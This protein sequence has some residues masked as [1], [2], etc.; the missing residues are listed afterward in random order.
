MFLLNCFRKVF[1]LIIAEDVTWSVFFSFIVVWKE[2]F[3]F[4][5]VPFECFIKW[6]RQVSG[7]CF[8]CF[9]LSD[10]SDVPL[11]HTGENIICLDHSQSMRKQLPVVTDRQTIA[12]NV[13]LLLHLSAH[14]FVLFFGPFIS[15]LWFTLPTNWLCAKVHY[16]YNN[17]ECSGIKTETKLWSTIEVE[18]NE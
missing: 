8:V 16:V 3:I 1:I 2:V 17:S 7:L 10:V 14:C 13:L 18:V 6:Y 11:S 9:G 5:A 15:F 4:P 12:K